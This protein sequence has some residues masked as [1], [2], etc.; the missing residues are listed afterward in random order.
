MTRTNRFLVT[1]NLAALAALGCALVTSGDS[2]SHA[3]GVAAG[4]SGGMIAVVGLSRES[5]ETLY[6]VDTENQLITAYET[7][8]SRGL[9]L[10]GARSYKYDS[11]MIEF[12]DL[13]EDGFRASELKKAFEKEAASDPVDP[14]KK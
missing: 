12:H 2:P 14:R 5:T 11:K 8:R 7:D 13:S 10:I 1:A 4:S 3:D 9:K 6:L